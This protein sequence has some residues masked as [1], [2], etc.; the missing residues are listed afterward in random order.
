MEPLPL[1]LTLMIMGTI[2]AI[3]YR[4]LHFHVAILVGS[5]VGGICLFA[6]LLNTFLPL[7]ETRVEPG[8]IVHAIGSTTI[9]ETLGDIGWLFYLGL[10][11]AL[12]LFIIAFFYMKEDESRNGTTIGPEGESN[13]DEISIFPTPEEDPDSYICQDQIHTYY[14]Q[15]PN[16]PTT[17]EEATSQ[18]HDDGIHEPNPLPA[19][20]DEAPPEG[21]YETQVRIRYMKAI[22]S[23]IH[24]NLDRIRSRAQTY[25]KRL[26][27]LA[28]RLM[29][30]CYLIQAHEAY[31]NGVNILGKRNIREQN[32][33]YIRANH[34]VEEFKKTA[35]LRP[36]QHIDW[37]HRYDSRRLILIVALLVVVE[38]LLSWFVLQ[39]GI[40]RAA[41]TTSLGAIILAITC[42]IGIGWLI[43]YSQRN[44]PNHVRLASI[45]GMILITSVYFFGFALLNGLRGDEAAQNTVWENFTSGLSAIQENFPAF[46]A[47]IINI[48]AWIVLI[49]HAAKYF[50]RFAGYDRVRSNFESS[51][52]V[53]QDTENDFKSNVDTSLG[54]VDKQVASDTDTARV[55]ARN[56]DDIEAKFAH[57]ED[58]FISHYEQYVKGEFTRIVQIYRKENKEARIEAVNPSPLYFQKEPATLDIPAIV[59]E[60]LAD[61]H[62]K[63]ACT[64]EMKEKTQ[65]VMERTNTERQLWQQERPNLQSK[66]Q[67]HAKETILAATE[68]REPQYDP[69]FTGNEHLV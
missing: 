33:A 36:A 50:P 35:K 46:I 25:F 31:L 19:R 29:P 8:G 3:I 16:R 44:Q 52:K 9:M 67:V 13:E 14:F 49:V 4:F 5:V 24:T 57:L 34:E 68:D 23:E 37:E 1:L 45:A 51:K 59:R 61:G 28:D 65:E 39:E 62:D 32:R 53:W 22:Q 26:Q 21:N 60:A 55:N 15:G 17:I 58:T 38:F 42:G 30:R 64:P 43:Q 54:N 63:P 2:T 27:E 48:G 18:G 11:W 66:M 41:I 6:L 56:L 7:L 10:I 40:G 69:D 47:A 12:T 20:T